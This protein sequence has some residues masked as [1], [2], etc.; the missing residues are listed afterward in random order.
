VAYAV[1]L[2]ATPLG[3]CPTATRSV[4]T[5]T[6]I[7]TTI[8]TFITNTITDDRDNDNK[9]NNNNNISNNTNL[10]NMKSGVPGTSPGTSFYLKIGAVFVLHRLACNMMF[11]CQMAFFAKISDPRVGGTY[12][13]L[14]NTMANLGGMW[15][16]LSPIR[17]TNFLPLPAF[18]SRPLS[19]L[20]LHCVRSLPL[21][22]FM[23]LTRVLPS[24]STV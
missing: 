10:Q 20:C 13:T 12:M 4:A 15:C 7:A 19:A 23:L 16:V 3:T 22:N 14:L 5:T 9:N 2:H 21:Y 24:L 17:A 8:A 18:F 6:V 1:L 11:V